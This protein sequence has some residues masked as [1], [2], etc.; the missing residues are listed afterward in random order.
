MGAAKREHWERGGGKE[1]RRD[2]EKRGCPF[3]HPHLH[4]HYVWPAQQE[5]LDLPPAED[6][7]SLIDLILTPVT[8]KNLS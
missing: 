4:P 2:W 3:S 7:E 1:M 6:H 8:E 5:L